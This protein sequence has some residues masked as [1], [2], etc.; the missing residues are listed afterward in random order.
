MKIDLRIIKILAKNPG[1]TP[2]ELYNI[3]STEKPT[4]MVNIY[5]LVHTLIKSFVIIKKK[6]K[7]YL[8]ETWM[9][10]YLDIADSIKD[11]Y[12]N[13]RAEI[14]L[15]PWETK[16]IFCNSLYEAQTMRSDFILSLWHK[17]PTKETLHFYNSHAYF[18]LWVP[19]TSYDIQEKVSWQW[20][21][22]WIIWNDTF[23]DRYGSELQT[24]Q[25]Y[26][27]VIV[28]NTPFLKEWYCLLVHGPFI[29]EIIFPEIVSDYFKLYFETTHKL[30]DFNIGFFQ[31]IFHI[32]QKYTIKIRSNE[33]EAEAYRK[34]LK[35]LFKKN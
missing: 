15:S 21:T 14:V 16:Y 9:Y 13:K 19:H 25:W 33:I 11:N 4:T 18:P 29:Y 24:Q 12:I 32:K 30:E 26:K 23:L 35:K 6:W 3:F 17:A 31:N 34:E 22:L 5:K 1:I 10:D 2:Q 8:H 28:P 27:T 20:N 7:L